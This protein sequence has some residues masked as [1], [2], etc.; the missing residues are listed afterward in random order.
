[1]NQAAINLNLNVSL[2]CAVCKV[3]RK[4]TGGFI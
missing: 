4:S 2:I 3:K 1:M